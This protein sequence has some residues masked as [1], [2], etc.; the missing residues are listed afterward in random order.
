MGYT[1]YWENH[2]EFTADE[3]N[4]LCSITKSIIKQAKLQGI[5]IVREYDDHRPPQID[6][7][8]GIPLAHGFY[9]RFNGKDDDGHETFCLS[10]GKTSFDCCKT[11]RKP[12]DAVCVAIL[13]TAQQINDKF[14]FRSDGIGEPDFC[15]DAMI[16]IDKAAA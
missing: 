5:D 4:A 16:L 10:R 2:R 12:Y 7:D 1:N 8:T 3:W 11:A 14:S 13:L 6:R 15:K 9:I